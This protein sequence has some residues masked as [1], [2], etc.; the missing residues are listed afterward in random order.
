M[1]KNLLIVG[2]SGLGKEILQLLKKITKENS[3]WNILGFVDDSKNIKNTKI[4]GY[5]VLGG[6]EYFETNSFCLVVIA[7]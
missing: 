3:D 1:M 7:I 2:A 6:I 4:N 5:T